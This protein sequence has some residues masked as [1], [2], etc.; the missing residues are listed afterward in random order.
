MGSAVEKE[1]MEACMIWQKA[2]NISFLQVT[3]KEG[4]DLIVRWDD[5][6]ADNL[7]FF[8]G[9]GGCLAKT[10][11]KQITLD[12]AEYWVLQSASVNPRK[13]PF[14]ILPVMVHEVGH[15][16]GLTHSGDPRDVMSL[17]YVEG[18]IALSELDLE[19]IK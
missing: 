7:F 17:Y 6:T 2:A 8:D 18:R 19:R 3:D 13:K 9:K 12:D 10:A 1:I 16:L 5:Q 15:A 11:K 14:Q 4:A